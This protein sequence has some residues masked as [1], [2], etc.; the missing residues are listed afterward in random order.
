MK[1]SNVWKHR[2]LSLFCATSLLFAGTSILSCS[3]DDDDDDDSPAVTLSSIAVNTENAAI[4]YK[5]GDTFSTAGIVVTATYSDETTKDVT[6]SAEFSTP[7]MSAEGTPEVTVSYTE[8]SVTKTATFTIK[9]SNSSTPPQTNVSLSSIS[10]NIEKA[11]TSYK[12]GDTF[13]TDGITVTATY[14]DET[15]KDVTSSANSTCSRESIFS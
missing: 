13:S 3:D 4:S 1:K 11:T 9:V 15:T 6:T 8:G 7:D 2:L 14:T 12:I 5:I 10:V